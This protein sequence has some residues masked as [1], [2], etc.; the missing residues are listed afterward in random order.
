M[1]S[2][3]QPA[4]S[5][6]KNPQEEFLPPLRDD[7]RLVPGPP[8]DN[9]TP[10]WTLHDPVRNLF[11]R[12]GWLE[13]ELLAR[14]SSPGRDQ[15]RVDQ[16][17][18][19]VNQSTTLTVGLEDVQS[20]YIFLLNSSLLE[21]SNQTALTALQ[22][23]YARKEN[24]FRW[25]LHHYLFFRIPLVRPDRF[26]EATLP[27]VRILCSRPMVFLLALAGLVGLFLA[28][29]QWE[30]FRHTFAYFFSVKGLMYYGL[31]LFGVKLVHELG[32]AYTAKYYGLK[33]PTMGVAFLVLW[34]MLYSDTT[35]SWKLTSRY[36][37]MSIV[38]AGALLELVLAVLAT[39]L[40]S[41]LPDG[42]LRSVCFVVATI[43][44][45]SSLV[46][47]LSPFMRFD[48]YFLLSDWLDVPNLQDRAFA[49]G[50]WFLRKTFLGLYEPTPDQFPKGKVRF[51]IVYAY[52]TWLYRVILFTTIALI[53]YHMFFKVLGVFLFAVEIVWFIFYP[54]Y[55]EMGHWWLKRS[56]IGF[57]NRNLLMTLALLLSLAALF[58]VPWKSNIAV[59]AL[60]KTRSFARIYPPVPARI[61]KVHVEEGQQV[62]KG[63]L[64]FSLASPHLLFK[65]RQA[66]AKRRAIEAQL[67]RQITH[68]E[69][70]EPRKIIQQQLAEVITELQG[71]QR[72]KKRLAIPAPSD[73]V[74]MD[75]AKG[76]RPGLWVN[77]TQL[78]ALLV[79]KSGMMVE[80][81]LGEREL[82]N[83]QHG[84]RGLF[85]QENRDMT[86]IPCVVEAIESISARSLQE[87]YLA[88]IYGGD[89]AVRMMESG[90]MVTNEGMYRIRLA[91]QAADMPGRQV[92]RGRVV[93]KGAAKSLFSRAWRGIYAVLIKESGF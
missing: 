88:S 52:A 17:I 57:C 51:L 67:A 1:N 40:W 73:G 6:E 33:I 75:M 9:G 26:L 61:E 7:L 4:P 84:D 3:Q 72:Q 48:G 25:L 32:H 55:R 15:V 16:L 66:A 59:P 39:L 45:I 69:L 47:N 44:W 22:V 82:E 36:A 29:Q 93:V 77:T 58:I 68:S 24:P 41:F 46:L 83:V 49:L 20:M 31:A 85:Y 18:N 11:F 13:F 70:L 56:E 71:I 8:L 63:D 53:V 62:R 23:K 86:P 65:E 10:T 89:V 34:P 91:P 38:A 27:V 12:I 78:L 35:E 19:N 74:V 14:W 50:K 87:P 5:S 90:R 80:G 43:T 21:S 30:T 60:L 92:A 28:V 79:D 81:Y 54:I 2:S 64:L 42:P 37:R 76:V